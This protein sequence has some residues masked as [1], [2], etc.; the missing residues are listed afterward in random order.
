V[1]LIIIAALARNR[2][3]GKGGSIPWHF[4]EDLKR[5]KR[6][7]MG[8][9]I[10]MGRVTYESI[11]KPLS[12]RKNVV[13]TTRSIPTSVSDS[14]T[15]VLTFPSPETALNALKHDEKVFI[16]GGGQ[17]YR[18]FLSLADEMYLTILSR[19]Y[20]GDTYFPEYEELVNTR[21]RLQNEEVHEDYTFR[22]FI[23]LK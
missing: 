1:K 22:D 10:V 17:L 19:E 15:S 18:Y 12:G 3:I 6:L 21:F 5:F 4:S 9:T 11:G 2:I 13:I 23:K 20:E 8:H 14:T 16:I 7:T